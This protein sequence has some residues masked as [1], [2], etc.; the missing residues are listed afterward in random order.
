MMQTFAQIIDALG[1]YAKIAEGVGCPPGTASSWKSRNDIPHRY[2]PKL[3][4]MATEQGVS[5]VT[6]ELLVKLGAE[7][8]AKNRD[9]V[10]A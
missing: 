2:W 4:E 9:E 5:G 3:V 10:A 7:P 1:G 8:R 6:F